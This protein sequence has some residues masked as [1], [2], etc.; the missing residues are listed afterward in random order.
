[1]RGAEAAPVVYDAAEARKV[2]TVFSAECNPT[3]DWH[4]IGLFHSHKTSG[5][6][7]NITRL[8]ACN[9]DELE[10]Y[11]GLSIG[12]TFVHRNHRHEFGMNYAAFNKPAS[13]L[14]WTRSGQV[15]P[16]VD[17]VMQLDADMLINRP[18]WP[19][20]LGV[21]YGTV[22]SA[23]YDYLVGTD[24]GLADFF[25]VKN[26]SLQARCGG[27][28][29][30]HLQD[31]TRIAPLWLKFTEK[32]REYACQEPTKFYKLASPREDSRD[33]QQ[34]KGRRRQFMWMVEM[35]GYVFGAAEA[36]V[37]HHK[38]L[39][40]MMSYVGNVHAKPGPYILHYG[41]DWQLKSK[42][43]TVYNFNKLTYQGLDPATCPRWFFPVVPEEAHNDRDWFCVKQMVDFNDALCEYYARRCR[44]VPQCP[45]RSRAVAAPEACADYTDNCFSWALKGE[46]TANPGFMLNEC[47]Q[48]CGACAQQ[49]VRLGAP[50]TCAD[51]LDG[52]TCAKLAI[53]GACV[54]RREEMLESCRESC[55]FCNASGQPER[56]KDTANHG[57]PDGSD[58]G[59]GAWSVDPPPGTPA[60]LPPPPPPP[61]PRPPPL[62]TQQQPETQLQPAAHAAA[63]SGFDQRLH[64]Q[65]AQAV[66][67]ERQQQPP[68]PQQQPLQQVQQHTQAGDGD[69]HAD[70]HR[71]RRARSEPLM[72]GDDVQV[73]LPDHAHTWPFTLVQALVFMIAGWLLRGWADS[74]RRRAASAAA[75]GGGR[76]RVG[77]GL[78][79]H[80]A[81]STP[82]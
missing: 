17:Y 71:R 25:G 70:R 24:S 62:S 76:M 26:K 56:P 27:M 1:M 81:A 58:L 19:H 31:L 29:V 63:T 7:G 64:E 32:I 74:R 8:L 61:R 77:R 80:S 34:V 11:H 49:R 9:P 44:V 12:P 52:E 2:H 16:G 55:D 33:V 36:G 38:V 68:Q 47:R 42:G 82:V 10:G 13:V 60:A 14:Y 50:E 69:E 6:P 72:P 23:P 39:R 78:R 75:P 65:V 28:H 57:C 66:A 51:D 35:Y 20:T 40:T 46:C 41:I 54:S 45:P 43:Q 15:P 21:S 73:G 4:A 67:Q 53:D 5:Q 22:L 3:F 48:S 59:R 79:S 18:V 37:P 30:F